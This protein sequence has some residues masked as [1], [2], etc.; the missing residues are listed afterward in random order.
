MDGERAPDTSIA[1]GTALSVIDADPAI[2]VAWLKAAGIW[3]VAA[4]RRRPR[5]LRRAR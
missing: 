1:A 5:V 3:S 4:E 2:G